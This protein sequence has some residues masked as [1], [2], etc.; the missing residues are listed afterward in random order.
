MAPSHR[1]H[2]SSSCTEDHWLG[3]MEFAGLLAEVISTARHRNRPDMPL[4]HAPGAPVFRGPDMMTF[5][6]KYESLASLTATDV[7]ES[8]II[9]MLPYYCSDESIRDKVMMMHGYTDRDW[10]ALKKRCWMC[11]GLLT[12]GPIHWSTPVDILSD[13]ARHSKAAM[14]MIWKV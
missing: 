2:D 11:F 1:A 13:S 12:A 10:A 6:H 14:M 5:V 8:N 7:T 9:G 3:S 4:P